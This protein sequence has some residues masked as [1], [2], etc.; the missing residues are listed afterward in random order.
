MEFAIQRSVTLPKVVLNIATLVTTTLLL[1]GPGNHLG[2]IRVGHLSFEGTDHCIASCS[3]A[4]CSS[5]LLC[6][7]GVWRG[8]P[9]AAIFDC[10]KDLEM[11]SDVLHLSKCFVGQAYGNPFGQGKSPSSNVGLWKPSLPLLSLGSRGGRSTNKLLL[12]ELYC[13]F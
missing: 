9:Q 6:F 2:Y 1:P 7:P 5:G 11:L 4:R 8:G 12:L 13:N 3:R 10:C